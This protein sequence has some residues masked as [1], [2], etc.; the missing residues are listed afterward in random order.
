MGDALP[1][2]LLVEDDDFVATM[3]G[4][5]LED[6][7]AVE[8]APSGEEAE[9]LLGR[10]DWDAVIMDIELDGMSGL[11]FLQIVR[12]ERPHTATLMLSSHKGFKY[13]VDAIRAGADGYL[14][15]PVPA[16]DLR[17]K[18]LELAATTA[19]R[20]GSSGGADAAPRDL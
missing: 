1:R 20:R 11:D 7:A 15:K 2:V 8:R 12:R 18:V 14:T 6:T 9:P 16:N 4:T 19:A 13:S 5:I 10:H 17:A 3:L